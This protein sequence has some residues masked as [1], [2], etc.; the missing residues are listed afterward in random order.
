MVNDVTNRIFTIVKEMT[1]EIPTI[2][3]TYDDLGLD[4]LDRVDLLMHVEQEFNIYI[5]DEVAQ[6]IKT[7]RLLV[8]VVNK[9][10]GNVGR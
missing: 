4:S 7:I 8:E 2:D 6:D 10:V 9:H 5:P 1:G 3:T